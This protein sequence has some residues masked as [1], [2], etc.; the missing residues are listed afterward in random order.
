M[1]AVIWCVYIPLSLVSFWALALC[2][3]DNFDFG[4]Q[5]PDKLEHVI[6]QLTSQNIG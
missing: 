2:I 6:L 1:Y 3:K 5:Y 4:K